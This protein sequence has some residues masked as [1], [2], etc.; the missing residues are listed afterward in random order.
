MDVA[1]NDYSRPYF[2]SC[3]RK[4]TPGFGGSALRRLGL[5]LVLTIACNSPVDPAAANGIASIQLTPDSAM[6]SGA[7]SVLSEDGAVVLSTE[8][9]DR[10]GQRLD[11]NLPPKWTS[12]DPATATVSQAGTVVGRRVG[13]VTIA[14]IIGSKRGYATID[15]VPPTDTG[16]AIIA[17]RGFRTLFPE[18][19]LVAITG[20]FDLG[21][22]A[23]ELDV[24]LTADGIPVL[25]HDATVDRTTN[26]TGQVSSLMLAQIERLDACSKFGHGTAPC[27]V[28]TLQ[29]ALQAAHGRGKLVLELKAPFPRNALAPL[30]A[31]LQQEDMSRDVLMTSFDYSI[32]NDLRDLD[33]GLPL[34]YLT[35]SMPTASVI[36]HFATLGRSAVMPEDSA[37]FADHQA[38]RAL[39]STAIAQGVD[40]VTWTVSSDVEAAT[41][42]ALGV[43]HIISDTPLDK[44]ALRLIASPRV[45]QRN[46]PRPTA[47]GP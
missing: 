1:R 29:S 9:F 33:A 38:A 10:D 4:P 34:G 11:L 18:N 31:E 45:Y 16:I 5:L 21:A 44:S 14:A 41:V 7:P 39:A 36:G 2:G 20:A 19:T 23:V 42:V 30:L 47:T 26:G 24:R 40:V 35:Y 43:R 37:L 8:L 28:P 22:D 17:H 27:P 13:V 25:M 32:L 46:A 3:R 6:L 15:V 12:S